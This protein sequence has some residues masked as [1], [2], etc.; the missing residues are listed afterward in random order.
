MAL[1]LALSGL[2]GVLVALLGYAI[3]FIRNVEDIVPDH[4]AEPI[5]ATTAPA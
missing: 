1:M 4:D 2:L 3:P 5:V